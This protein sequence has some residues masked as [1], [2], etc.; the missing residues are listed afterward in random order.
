MAVKFVQDTCVCVVT[1]V[2]ARGLRIKTLGRYTDAELKRKIL[3][4]YS[5]C[6]MT[7]MMRKFSRKMWERSI[8]LPKMETCSIV[9]RK[10]VFQADMASRFLPT[11]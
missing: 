7:T 6:R 10:G 2:T 5:C 3:L 9:S 8:F 11:S 1:H 4:Q